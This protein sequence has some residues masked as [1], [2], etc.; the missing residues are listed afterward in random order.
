MLGGQVWLSKPVL[1]RTCVQGGDDAHPQGQAL[2][3]DSHFVLISVTPGMSLPL[4]RMARHPVL[5]GPSWGQARA[6]H[7]QDTGGAERAGARPRTV[8]PGS[9]R[10]EEAEVI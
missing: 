1:D 6:R 7:L 10:P 8:S 5:G 4:K 2:G 9:A 3:P